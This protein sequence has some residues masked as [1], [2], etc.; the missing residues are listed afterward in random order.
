MT[1]GRDPISDIVRPPSWE[2]SQ[3][4][5]PPQFVPISYCFNVFYCR[6]ALHTCLHPLNIYIYPPPQFQIP[7]NNPGS[8]Y[9]VSKPTFSPYLYSNVPI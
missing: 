5:P 2:T 8:H 6:F 1:S 7:G 4:P 9:S 3:T